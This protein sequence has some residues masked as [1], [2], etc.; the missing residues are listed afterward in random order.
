V[1]YAACVYELPPLTDAGGPYL[2]AAESAIGLDGSGW[3][4]GGEE[5]GFAWTA[6]SGSFDDAT[7]EDPQYTAGAEA[8]IFELALTVTDPG[9]LSHTYTTMMVV[10]DDEAGSVTGGGWIMSPEGAC[11]FGECGENTT[12][13]A[14]FGFVSKCKRGADSPTGQTEFQ[15]KAG[16]LDFHSSSYEWLVIAGANAKYKGMGTIKGDGNYGF[17]RTATDAAV[18]DHD[19]HDV[20]LFRIKTWD[21]NSGDTVVYDNKMGADENG[22]DGTEIGGGNIKVHKGK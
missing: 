8:G 11:Q 4:S 19:A 22:Y 16:G 13:K 14:N 2:V 17:M 20:D 1:A 5:L 18:N 7:V 15:F 6:A 10:Y 9:G 3:D 21:K 12:G